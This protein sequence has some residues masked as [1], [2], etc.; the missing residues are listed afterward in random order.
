MKYYKFLQKGTYRTLHRG[1]KLP[2]PGQLSSPIHNIRPSG[3][4]GTNSGIGYHAYTKDIL[5][6]ITDIKYNT[7]ADLW[8]VNVY[9]QTQQYEVVRDGPASV[10]PPHP[11]T[12][13][14]AES[15]EL[16]KKVPFFVVVGGR[17]QL[18]EL[19]IVDR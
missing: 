12:C 5:P 6:F 17:L 1:M 13:I 19:T 14:V 4:A 9:G 10:F 7:L 8:I 18:L 15:I 16:I 2:P 3:S 11:M